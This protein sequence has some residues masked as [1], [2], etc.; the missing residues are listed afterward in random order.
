M[1]N[2]KRQWKKDYYNLNSE[3]IKVD[4]EAGTCFYMGATL[5]FSNADRACYYYNSD[6]EGHVKV[7]IEVDNYELINLNGL[8]RS[9]TTTPTTHLTNETVYL[10]DYFRALCYRY[11]HVQAQWLSTFDTSA[12]IPTAYS[13]VWSDDKIKCTG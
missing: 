11:N 10:V 1:F 13:G 8:F 9:T 5:R 6:G 4:I 3:K 12:N 2:S 7:P